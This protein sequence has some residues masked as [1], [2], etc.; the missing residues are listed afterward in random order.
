M[1]GSF[2]ANFIRTNFGGTK[3]TLAVTG[4]PVTITGEVI[5]NTDNNIVGLR[6]ENG[7]RVFINADL[8][9]FVF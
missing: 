2:M 9:A 4:L 5:G 8:I 6:L 7:N 3:I 1:E